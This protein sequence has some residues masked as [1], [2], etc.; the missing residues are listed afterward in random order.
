MGRYLFS[1][2]SG[3]L[4]VLLAVSFITFF[5]MKIAPGGPAHPVPFATGDR[6]TRELMDERF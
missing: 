5:L 2:I 3:I 4:G 1:R 6:C